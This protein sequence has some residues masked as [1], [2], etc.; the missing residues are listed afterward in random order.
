MAKKKKEKKAEDKDKRTQER[1]NLDSGPEL[2]RQNLLFS[3]MHK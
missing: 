2:G 1:K 3:R